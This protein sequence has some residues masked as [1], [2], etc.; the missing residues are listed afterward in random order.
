MKDYYEILG[1]SR[2]ASEEEIKSVY[3]KLA[4]KYH[5]D[6]NKGPDAEE[7]FKDINEAYAILSDSLKRADY[8]QEL[9]GVVRQKT[10]EK[11]G[12]PSGGYEQ[13]VAQKPT[14]AMYLAAF[15]RAFGGH[16][17]RVETTADFAPAF[18]RARASGKPAILHCFI[19]PEAITP[20]T[21]ITAIRN[22]PR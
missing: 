4:H 5:P 7:K 1:V 6:V 9:A 20:S 12:A 10:E 16:G 15:A 17:E 21:T 2:K 13:A 19:D 22:R 8:D 14:A 11:A 18:E 3:Y